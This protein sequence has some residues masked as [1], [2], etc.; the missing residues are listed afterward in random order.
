LKEIAEHGLEVDEDISLSQLG[1]PVFQIIEDSLDDLI[2]P[3]FKV[4]G[5]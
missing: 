1:K 4:Q 2:W 3:N 5:P